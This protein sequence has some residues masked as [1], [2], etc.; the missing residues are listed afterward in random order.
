MQ[1][2]DNNSL[3]SELERAKCG[4]EE[5]LN[6]LCRDAEVRL[7]LVVKY[8]LRGW[9]REDQEDLVQSTLL[10]FCE[11]IQLVE[12]TPMAFALWI[13]R[14]KIGSELQKVRRQKEGSLTEYVQSENGHDPARVHR[15]AVLK[16]PDNVEDEF[17]RREKVQRVLDAMTHLSEFCRAV[18]TGILEGMRIA[19]IWDRFQRIE[20][21]LTR[22]AFDKRV[23]A[24][25]QR[26]FNIL[27]TEA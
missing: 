4:D 5:S 25:R 8:R 19:E 9:S 3:E 13:L 14:Q 27:G 10:T 26:L 23:H 12:H 1:E 2:I 6:R 21:Q 18:M 20:P 17:E 16:A 11:K 7:K 24:C 22:S 15:G